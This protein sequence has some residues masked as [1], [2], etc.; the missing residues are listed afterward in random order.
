MQI[1]IFSLERCCEWEA[2]TL[3][4][5]HERVEWPEK[6][7]LG[8]SLTGFQEKSVL[9]RKYPHFPAFYLEICFPLHTKPGGLF[10]G[11]HFTGG[12]LTAHRSEPQLE[13][14]NTTWKEKCK[15]WRRERWE[16]FGAHS[17]SENGWKV[18]E[19]L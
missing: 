19:Q 8:S 17:R 4:R 5:T 10:G 12:G 15:Y 7:V 11:Q 6:T 9:L 14:H 13:K 18:T 3:T 2:H 1:M 16:E